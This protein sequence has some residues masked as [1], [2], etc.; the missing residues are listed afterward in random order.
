MS[1][2]RELF[3]PSTAFADVSRRPPPLDLKNN[4]AW[5]VSLEPTLP[6]LG[7]P[8]SPTPPPGQKQRTV[9]LPGLMSPISLDV[10]TP[11]NAVSFSMTTPPPLSR[12]SRSS[13]LSSTASSNREQPITPSPI[14]GQTSDMLSSTFADF[15]ISAEEDPTPY[16]ALSPSVGSPVQ[17]KGESKEEMR[18]PLPPFRLYGDLPRTPVRGNQNQ[19]TIRA[20]GAP[21]RASHRSV[22][23][24]PSSSALQ[25]AMGMHSK[26]KATRFNELNDNEVNN[27]NTHRLRPIVP[28]SCNA[29]QMATGLISPAPTTRSNKS[30]SS[31][32]STM[33]SSS[34]SSSISSSRRALPQRRPLPMDWIGYH[35][36][37]NRI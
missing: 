21:L 30:S 36:K 9:E 22:P 6:V 31:S 35:P 4:L 13:S 32:A 28:K 15:L 16:I 19:E 24:P 17:A 26:P 10:T 11:K 33:S 37:G 27:N 7:S 25:K 12:S 29:L 18:F 14:T 8:F 23:P 1:P 3:N 2:C 20:P 5:R 34:S